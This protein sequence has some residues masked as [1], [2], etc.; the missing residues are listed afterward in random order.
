MQRSV[1]IAIRIETRLEGENDRAVSQNTSLTGGS[2]KTI[3]AVYWL[4]R[5]GCSLEMLMSILNMN[6]PLESRG[7]PVINLESL[8]CCFKHVSNLYILIITIAT[9]SKTLYYFRITWKF[10]VCHKVALIVYTK[11]LPGTLREG[12]QHG[13]H[14]WLGIF[15]GKNSSSERNA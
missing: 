8:Q 14:L 4:M 2:N 7:H 3:T 11:K 15:H 9:F 12:C 6:M 10:L 1:G 5:M 13:I